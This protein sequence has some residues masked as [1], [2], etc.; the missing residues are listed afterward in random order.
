MSTYSKE[1]KLYLQKQKKEKRLVTISRLMIVILFLVIWELLSKYN[2]INSFL[3]SRPS[4]V[5]KTIITLWQEN[6]LFMHIGITIYEVL[7][8]F[9]TQKKKE[10]NPEL[11]DTIERNMILRI[12]DKNWTQQID[13]MNRFRESVSLRSYGQIN[14]L[15]DYVN[16]GW[17]MFREMLETIS[18][19]AV[20]NLLNVKVQPKTEVKKNEFTINVQPTQENKESVAPTMENAKPIVEG[21]AAKENIK[22]ESTANE[23]VDLTK[24]NL[25]ISHIDEGKEAAR[26]FSQDDIHTN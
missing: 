25:N 16:E 17:G 8:S 23:G 4:E 2:V 7:L 3:S 10:W 12:I 14:P 13:N 22:V 24:P 26:E 1:H 9:Y 19:E 18:L 6:T 21:D 20:L 5:L 15:Q 11:A